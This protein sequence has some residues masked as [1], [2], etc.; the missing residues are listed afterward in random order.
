VPVFPPYVRLC[1]GHALSVLCRRF[2]R[3]QLMYKP[4]YCTS[5]GAVPPPISP[6]G[7]ARVRV[8]PAQLGPGRRTRTGPGRRELLWG[9]LKKLQRQDTTP[10]TRGPGRPQISW[11]W[12]EQHISIAATNSLRAAADAVRERLNDLWRLE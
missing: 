7:I 9:G 11:L 1:G 6:E 8:P 2:A 4:G 3:H 5:A 12:R 10:E